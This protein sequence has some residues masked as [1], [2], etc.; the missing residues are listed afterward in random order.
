R[1]CQWI[2]EFA[3]GGVYDQEESKL[4]DLT[5]PLPPY[6]LDKVLIPA[7]RAGKRSVVLLEEW[8]TAAAA[9]TLA[10]EIKA[11]GQ[12]EQSVLFWNAN[13]STASIASTGSTSP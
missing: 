13:N 5:R 9:C 10:D 8:Q 4:A 3:P 7:W 12:R 1:W 11:I 2:S 6:A